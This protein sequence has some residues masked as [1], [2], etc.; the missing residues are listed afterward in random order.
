M[1]AVVAEWRRD[2]QAL[3]ERYADLEREHAELQGKC[4]RLHTGYQSAL[5]RLYARPRS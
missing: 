3:A 5:Q 4:H 1:E 2:F